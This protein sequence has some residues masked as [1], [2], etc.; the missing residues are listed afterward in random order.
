M[1]FTLGPGD[2]GKELKV[3]AVAFQRVNGIHLFFDGAGGRPNISF[4]CTSLSIGF[5]CCFVY[6][7]GECTTISSLKFA[8]SVIQS[9][10][11]SKLEKVG[12]DE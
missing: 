4:E 9:A 10:D 11:A 2:F 5:P 3:K 8:G 7:A 12:H 1:K 6:H